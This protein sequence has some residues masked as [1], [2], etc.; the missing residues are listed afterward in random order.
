[1]ALIRYITSY[2]SFFSYFSNTILL[3]CFLGLGFGFL[4]SKTKF[5]WMNYAG[6]LLLCLIVILTITFYN[7]DLNANLDYEAEEYIATGTGTTSIYVVIMIIFILNALYFVQFGQTTGRLMP[8]FPPIKAYSLNI[9]G[10]ILGVAVFSLLSF[11]R[12]PP[13]IWLAIGLL[14]CLLF[15]KERV[16]IILNLVIFILLIFFSYN[17]DRH[18]IW[19]PYYRLT[20]SAPIKDKN[21]K[22]P[23]LY[24]ILANNIY[25]Q[26]VIDSNLDYSK[27]VRNDQPLGEREFLLKIE[28]CN[29]LMDYAFKLKKVED[30]LI[31]GSGA[32]RDTEFAVKNKVKN[33]D[34]VEID[35]VIA[36][37]G[38]NLSPNHVY[39]NTGVH[40][41]IND[42]RAFLKNTDHKYD[43][44]I[45]AFIDS[46]RLFST[47]SSLRL[48]NFI[49][50]LDCFE[51]I[52]NHLKDDGLMIV[53]HCF[54]DWR[55]DR[56]S[57]MLKKVFGQQPYVVEYNRNLV[58]TELNRSFI[59]S[60]NGS[61]SKL[62]KISLDKFLAPVNQDEI[63]SNE[64]TLPTD[65]WPFFFLREKNRM[66][67]HYIY[68]IIMVLAV[69]LAFTVPFL[70]KDIGALDWHYFFLGAA[71]MLLETKSITRFALLF[72][73][74]WIVNSI[75][76]AAIL[77]MILLS[78]LYVAKKKPAVKNLR[79][80]Y[81]LLFAALL[82]NL[83]IGD[84]V[85]LGLNTA[86]RLASSAIFTFLPIFFAGIIFA[87]GLRKEEDI[88]YVLGANLLGTMLGGIF[89]YSSL[90][91]GFNMLTVFV[92]L[93]Y[94]ASYKT[95][96]L[97]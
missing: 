87:V 7:I 8:D 24:G 35:P 25:H 3:S 69:S 29:R 51:S 42:A 26:S 13:F 71:F 23:I 4:I 30:V 20:I 93:F 66:P 14:P 70:P 76:I 6:A 34:A 55:A 95:L 60:K 78:N 10:S 86:S 79:F 52:K 17:I 18:F 82:L 67:R 88:S 90:L 56:L 31:L 96:K 27:L 84:K 48:E 50:T 46:H 72:G 49:Y 43:M 1:M 77:F 85:F 57:S 75:V 33:I 74:T 61:N 59:C 47:F 40:L 11:M 22:I 37:L 91:Y 97:T 21:T 80:C 12:A 81:L 16:W 39:K 92:I 41:Y 38:E 64:V 58:H 19:S 5:S 54:A 63:H 9:G 36:R 2:V 32:G 44:V 94:A 15:V 62:E 83:L 28:A 73:T 89:E 68:F 65:D 45:I 53:S